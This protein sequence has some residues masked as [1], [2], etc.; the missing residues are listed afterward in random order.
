MAS[1][2]FKFNGRDEIM[3]GDSGVILT[4]DKDSHKK[5]TRCN[6]KIY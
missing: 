4:L 5:T 6:H 1:G 2:I 3:G